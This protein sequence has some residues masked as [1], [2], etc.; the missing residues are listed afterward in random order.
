M[1]APSGALSGRLPAWFR[2]DLPDPQALS[3][4]KARLERQGLKTVCE[5]ARCPNRGG[6]WSK[7]TLTF[8]ILGDMCTRACRFCAVKSGVPSPV[9]AEEPERVARM[10]RELGLRHAVITS[11]TREDLDDQ[12]ANQF[13]LTVSAVKKF[14]PRTVVEVLIPDFLAREDCLRRLACAKPDVVGHNI[15][16]VRRLSRAL[17]PQADH[18]RS[19]RTLALARGI[20]PEAVIKSGLMAGLGETEQEILSTLQ[21]LKGAGCDMVTIGQYL[22]PKAGRCVPV[23]R[24]VP[25]DEF[26]RYR[27]EGVRCGLKAVLAGPLVRSS[28][29][30]EEAYGDIMRTQER[31]FQ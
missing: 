2:Q 26:D 27:E 24:F 28:Y 25:P 5:D 15:E 16:T 17:R 1:T 4:M 21:E 11:V 23:E 3:L 22:S 6:C 14:S 19:L 20:F 30:A 18:D 29:M 31:V 13:A 10:V 9:S 7:G 8:M 12:G